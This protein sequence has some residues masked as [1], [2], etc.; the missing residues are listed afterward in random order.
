MVVYGGLRL[1]GCLRLFMEVYG[2]MVVYGCLW[3]F[4]EPQVRHI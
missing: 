1:Y 2:C 3:L 4:T